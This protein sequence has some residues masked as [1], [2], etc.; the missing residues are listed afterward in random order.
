M[1][2]PLRER[3]VQSNMG[4][5]KGHEEPKIPLRASRVEYLHPVPVVSVLGK[6]DLTLCCHSLNLVF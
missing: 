1:T 5:I 6:Q 3:L 2:K 4:T